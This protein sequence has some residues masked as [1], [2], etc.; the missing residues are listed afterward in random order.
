M[1]KTAP[2]TS[3]GAG[4]SEPGTAAG[5]VRGLPEQWLQASAGAAGGGDDALMVCCLPLSMRTPDAAAGKRR[6]LGAAKTV[7]DQAG[8]A[9]GLTMHP[10]QAIILHIKTGPCEDG[11]LV[12]SYEKRSADALRQSA[13]P[14]HGCPTPEAPPIPGALQGDPQGDR[15]RALTAG[16]RFANACG[17][18]RC[19]CLQ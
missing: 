3:L 1:R 10:P 6:H 5:S 19:I 11:T 12:N 2:G 9:V 17:Q 16:Y 8:Q 4:L 15:Q 18:T 13:R 14:A 7:H